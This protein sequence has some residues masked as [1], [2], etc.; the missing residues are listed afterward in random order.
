MT[1]RTQNL[2]IADKFILSVV[3][4]RSYPLFAAVCLNSFKCWLFGESLSSRWAEVSVLPL[5]LLALKWCLH[6]DTC[7]ACMYDVH[8][9]RL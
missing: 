2:V 7:T 6:Y 3:G 5:Q 9:R 8:V 1:S 4:N